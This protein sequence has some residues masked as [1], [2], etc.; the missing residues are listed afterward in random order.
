[1]NFEDWKLE[2]L[3]LGN[4]W[5]STSSNQFSKRQSLTGVWK[6]KHSNKMINA[7]NNNI[8]FT[9]TFDEYLYKCFEAGLDCPNQISKKGDSTKIFQLGRYKDLGGYTIDN[10]RFI[11][12]QENLLEKLEHNNEANKKISKSLSGRT[13]NNKHKNNISITRKNLSKKGK[14]PVNNLPPWGNF[15]SNNKSLEVWSKAPECYELWIKNI[16]KRYGRICLN[17]D[18][19]LASPKACQNMINKFKSGWNPSKDP[20]WKNWSTSYAKCA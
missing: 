9:L 7:N 17:R 16:N 15:N 3:E 1:M 4:L 18:L 13:L 20:D 19:N 6:L 14:L 12:M 10:C 8:I 5:F 11:T 2:Q